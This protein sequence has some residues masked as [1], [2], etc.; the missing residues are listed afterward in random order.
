MDVVVAQVQ[1]EDVADVKSHISAVSSPWPYP[2]VNSIFL[3]PLSKLAECSCLD[4][5]SAGPAVQVELV[6]VVAL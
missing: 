2:P 3:L 5:A 6:G 4:L 1:L